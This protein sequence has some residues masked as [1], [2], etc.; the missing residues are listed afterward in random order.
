[1]RAHHIGKIPAINLLMTNGI[2]SGVTK[3]QQPLANSANGAVRSAQEVANGSPFRVNPA[4]TDS[5]VR[6]QAGQEGVATS[7]INDLALGERS[8]D[9]GARFLIQS[10]NLAQQAAQELDGDGVTEGDGA[11]EPT[12]QPEVVSHPGIQAYQ[13]TAELF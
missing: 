12:P 7:S 5:S 10:L 1:M 8:V 3:T 6:N 2:Y 4:Q 11:A 13:D 9:A